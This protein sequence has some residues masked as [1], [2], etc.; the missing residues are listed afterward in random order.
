[1]GDSVLS[2]Q[3]FNEL[4]KRGNNP[5]YNM[6]PDTLSCLSRLRVASETAPE[7]AA[8]A[9][10]L[11]PFSAEMFRETVRFLIGFINKD[12]QSESLAEK[13]LHRFGD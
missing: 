3:F 5:I 7:G 10:E 4:S 2:V 13:L 1:M 6:L 8:A 12:K 11:R 9:E